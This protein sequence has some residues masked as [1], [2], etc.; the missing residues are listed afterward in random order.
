MN[1]FVINEAELALLANAIQHCPFHL[2]EGMMNVV[3]GVAQRPLLSEAGPYT[4]DAEPPT[5][6][7]APA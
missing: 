5:P 4:Q 2:A 3:R 7:E 1:N 6:E